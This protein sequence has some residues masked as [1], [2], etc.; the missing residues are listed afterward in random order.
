MLIV[1]ALRLLFA[2]HI[3]E[4]LHTGVMLP[5][6]VELLPCT[7]AQLGHV[8]TE[9]SAIFRL[10]DVLQRLFILV[11]VGVARRLIFHLRRF[12]VRFIARVQSEFE[13]RLNI[14]MFVRGCV[15]N[16]YG[17]QDAADRAL[18]FRSRCRRVIGQIVLGCNDEDRPTRFE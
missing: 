9:Q 10:D 14:H 7:N 8:T 13:N 6:I 16:G 11:S 15:N 18:E 12:S 1:Q 2:E 5:S 17:G 4:G 3:V